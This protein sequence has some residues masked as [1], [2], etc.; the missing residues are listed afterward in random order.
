MTSGLFLAV[1][2]VLLLDEKRLNSAHALNSTATAR[3]QSPPHMSTEPMQNDS[4]KP[5]MAVRN[6]P[7]ITTMTPVTRYTAL[8]R[9][10]A[11]SASD[12]PI[13]TMNT[14]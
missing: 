4:M 6:Q 13:D 2:L 5:M 14:T 3:P 9:P 11:R 1:F 10:H 12:E 8:S 7:I